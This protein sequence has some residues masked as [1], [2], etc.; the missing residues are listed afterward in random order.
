MGNVVGPTWGKEVAGILM[1]GGQWK[2]TKDLQESSQEHDEQMRELENLMKTKNE[3]MGKMF[4]VVMQAAEQG[5]LDSPE[6]KPFIAEVVRTLETQM[7]VAP[8]SINPEM[9]AAVLPSLTTEASKQAKVGTRIAEATEGDVIAQVGQRTAA[10]EQALDK[11][12]IDLLLGARTLE[13]DPADYER[14]VRQEETDIRAREA[15]I[16]TAEAQEEAIRKETEWLDETLGSRVALNTAQARRLNAEAD[17]LANE[18]LAKAKGVL[19]PDTMRA[20]NERARIRFLGVEKKDKK[21]V[22]AALKDVMLMYEEAGWPLP[23]TVVWEMGKENYGSVSLFFSRLWHK[24]SWEEEYLDTS[25]ITTQTRGTEILGPR[26]EGADA[27]ARQ[28][29]E[30]AQKKREEEKSAEDEALGG[31]IGSVNPEDS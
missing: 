17:M 24:K 31:F 10:G 27:A 18:M 9:F 14:R 19:D 23:T 13:R 21:Q 5:N 12:A 20:V 4:D 8:G 29:V 1:Q 28:A 2:Q 30:D 7:E 6:M 22:A 25:R 3:Y 11:G 15:G 16:G 26:P